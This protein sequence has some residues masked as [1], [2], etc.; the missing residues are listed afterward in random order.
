MIRVLLAD[1]QGL[2]RAGLRM[3]LLA[4]PDIDVVGEAGNGAEAV[5]RPREL[6][7]DV[8][9]MD[10]RMPKLD[11]IEAT[12]RITALTP[13]PRVLVLDHLRPRRIRLRVAARRRQRVPPQRRAGRAAC[14]RGTCRRRRR[15]AVRPSVTRRLIEEFA[16]PASAAAPAA[17]TELTAREQEV[18]R[19]VA[20][21]RSTPRSERNSSS[22][23][24]PRKRT[25][26][27]SCRS[28]TSETA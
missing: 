4:E 28:S 22:A 6:R 1:D 11:G 16:R 18:L 3:I 13:A 24:T 5:D 20:R 2:V 26:R 25:W 21:G 15:I 7:P 27:A 10:I 19:L 17:L 9:L 8:V 12:R 23:S 14:C